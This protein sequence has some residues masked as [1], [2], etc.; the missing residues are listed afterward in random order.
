[1]YHMVANDFAIWTWPSKKRCFRI[2]ARLF[3]LARWLTR[4]AHDAEDT[5]LDV[6]AARSRKQ[7]RPGA[8][9]DN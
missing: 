4:N 7:I 5:I 3:D 8:M 1:V 9:G 2:W 6:I